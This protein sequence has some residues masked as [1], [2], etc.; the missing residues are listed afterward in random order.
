MSFLLK[1]LLFFIIPLIPGY[2]LFAF[3]FKEE[4]NPA[5]AIVYSIGFVP[6]FNLLIFY[7]L[8]LL[9]PGLP[10]LFY[11]LAPLLFISLLFLFIP[12]KNKKKLQLPNSSLSYLG[13][14]IFSIV[15]SYIYA[16]AKPVSEHDTLEYALQGR[17]FFN[18]RSVYY[19]SYPFHAEN[20]FYYVGLHGFAFP[21]IYTWELMFNQLIGSDSI[22]LFK[23]INPFYATLLLGLVYEE[24]KIVGKKYAFW[25]VLV[26]LFTTGFI[27]NALQFHL[28]MLRQYLFLAF[29]ASFIK[30]LKN[31]SIKNIL[32]FSVIAGLQSTVH[33]IGAI[34]SAIA[35]VILMAYAI[36][37]KT[38]KKYIHAIYSVIALVLF[39]W[40]HYILD[41][42]IGTG[43]ILK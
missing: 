39:G 43:W 14:L 34:A 33:S 11:V 38:D 28:E 32:L 1:F 25:A 6:V 17:H 29:A 23:F 30:A 8:L 12:E 15:I 20:G 13:I 37:Q 4:H 26:L 41:I 35:I 31:N 3:V 5:K 40:I 42:L 9:L 36:F 22:I 19:T 2:Y 10:I 16:Q 27:F 7:Y 18:T 21:L 24:V